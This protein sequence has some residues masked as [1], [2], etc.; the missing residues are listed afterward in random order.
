M[1]VTRRPAVL[2]EEFK[3]HRYETHVC[4]VE[5][6]VTVVRKHVFDGLGENRRPI[7]LEV[8]TLSLTAFEVQGSLP[9]YKHSFDN[10]T[11]NMDATFNEFCKFS[12]FLQ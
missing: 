11:D 6:S 2:L 5:A 12:S 10:P 3:T 8:G 4:V 9:D 7:Y 1:V